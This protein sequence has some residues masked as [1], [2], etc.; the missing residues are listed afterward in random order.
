MAHKE[1]GM[2][3]EIQGTQLSTPRKQVAM[4]R[5]FLFRRESQL[6]IP[7]RDNISPDPETACDALVKPFDCTY[8]QARSRGVNCHCFQEKP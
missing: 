3:S 6:K 5:S 2:K 8:N 7:G 1:T 4:H